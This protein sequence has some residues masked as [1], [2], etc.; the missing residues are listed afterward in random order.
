MPLVYVSTV[1]NVR[2]GRNVII[3]QS[4][5]SP[6]ITKGESAV[7]CV[8]PRIE[9]GLRRCDGCQVHHAQGQV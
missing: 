1:L 6:K 8:V 7:Q 3:E 9:R 4:F 5:G 2:A